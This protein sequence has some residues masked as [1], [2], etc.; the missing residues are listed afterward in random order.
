[1]FHVRSPEC[2]PSP[3]AGAATHIASGLCYSGQVSRNQDEFSVF[4]FRFL[5]S[6]RHLASSL[7][8]VSQPYHTTSR[9]SSE[10]HHGAQL[11]HYRQRQ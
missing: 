5:T 9:T 1:M 7:K 8:F 4:F 3:I 11:H 2:L 10:D 6:S